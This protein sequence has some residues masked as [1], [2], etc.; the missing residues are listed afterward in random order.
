[1]PLL[2]SPDQATPAGRRDH[3]M[4]QVAITAGLRVSELTALSTSDIH[5]GHAAHVACTGKG[6]KKRMTPLDRPTVAILREYVATLPAATQNLFPTR[7]GT[8]M[9]RD[10]VAARLIR[11]LTWR[12]FG[13]HSAKPLMA[14]AMLSFGGLPLALPGLA[15]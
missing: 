15:A 1:M 8:R 14:M 7:S 2:A 4:L 12:A 5:L 11:L 13:F 6:R 9:S 10:A 3:A